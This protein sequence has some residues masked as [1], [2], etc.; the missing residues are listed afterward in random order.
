M[1]E[2]AT[3]GP[4]EVPYGRGYRML[5]IDEVAD[6]FRVP[7][8]TVRGWVRR[9]AIP[10]RKVG[11]TLRFAEA[12]VEAASRDVGTKKPRTA[13]RG[14]D[15]P[16]PAVVVPRRAARTPRTTTKYKY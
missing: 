6:W 2:P 5:T 3:V 7:T 14:P 8:E 13:K 15:E 1:T 11:Q 16:T 4:D 9:N 12:E 10:Y